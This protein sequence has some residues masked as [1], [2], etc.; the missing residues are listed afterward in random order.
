MK[1]QALFDRRS[2]TSPTLLLLV[3]CST[4][5]AIHLTLVLK[6]GSPDR[7]ITSMLFWA[8]A[9]YLIWERQSQ[10]KYHTSLAASSFGAVLLSLLLVKT[11]GYC[12]ESF[13]IIYPLIA[14]IALATI[15]SGFQ[16][17]KEYWRELMLLFFSGIPEVLLATL[18][19][20]SPLTAQFATAMLWYAG[21][22]V[23]QN[24]IYIQMPGGVVQVYSGCSGVVAM[25]QL[26][27]MSILF[28]MLLPLPWKRSQKLIIPVA[29]I[30]IGF[31]VNAARVALMAILVSQ[32]QMKSFEY[33]HE[34]SG[35]LV[36]SVIGTI[37][38][39]GLV[40]LLIKFFTPALPVREDAE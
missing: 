15:A 5:I 2:L 12:E 9:A 6:I 3:L 36:F 40:W 4:V 7:Q 24:G 27:G 37:L 16:G 32:K 22:P 39:V 18:T 31:V 17:L 29:A 23:T 33:W 19:D 20:P 8:T 30:A 25:T 21:F 10:L 1:Q 13:L 11:T 14:G 35:S 28:L 26:L 38:L 34:G